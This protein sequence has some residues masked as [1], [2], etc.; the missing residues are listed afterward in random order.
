MQVSRFLRLGS[1]GYVCWCPACEEPHQLPFPNRGWAF[2]GNV[3]CPTF[4]PSFKITDGRGAICHFTL[5]AAVLMFTADCTH[6]F[7][8]RVVPLPELPEHLRDPCDWSDG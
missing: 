3:D 1:G 4:S 6:A 5:K 8:G 7:A 2:D